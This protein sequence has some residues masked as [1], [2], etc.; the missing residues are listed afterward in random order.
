MTKRFKTIAILAICAVSILGLCSCGSNNDQ[1]EGKLSVVATVFPAYDWTREVI[2]DSDD[3]ELTLLLDNGT[4]IHSYQP[5]ASD[6]MKISNADVFIYVG[7]ESDEWVE[8]ALEEANNKDMKVIS[9]LDALGD[10]KKVEEVVPGMQE[11]D[12]HDDHDNH[13][14]HDHD[15]DELEYDEHVWLSISNAKHLTSEIEKAIEEK[16]PSNAKLYKD[17]LD[18][19]LA[20]LDALDK[21]YRNVIGSSNHKTLIFGDRFP[22]RYLTD[23]YGLDYFAA[24]VGC[25]AETE[26]SFDTVVFLAKKVDEL[27]VPTVLTIDKSDGKIAKTII[28]NTK[29]HNQAVLSLNSMQAVTSDEQKD[30]A[31]FISIM[32]DNLDVLKKALN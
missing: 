26:A 27:G 20:E 9:L 32:E 2:G 28:K 31:T 23:E 13:D 5:T 29:K 15:A 3:I 1:A 22:F 30:G 12:E 7:G 11:E 16:D 25:S 21:D 10:K 18:G 4:D 14:G 8:D 6:M 17:N 19:Y 24:F